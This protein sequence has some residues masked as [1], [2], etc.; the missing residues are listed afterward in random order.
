[1]LGEGELSLPRGDLDVRLRRFVEESWARS[2]T[3]GIDPRHLRRQA[4][5]RATL[6][7][8]QERARALLEAA[9]PAVAL[10]HA[11]LHNEPHMVALSDAEGFIIRLAASEPHEEAINFFEGASWHEHDIGTNGIGTALAARAPVLVTGPEH[12]V[13]DYRHWTCVGV[14]LRGPDGRVL[15]ALDLSV[16]NER[17]NPHTWGWTLSLA[18]SIE[19]QLART[20][21]PATFTS[22]ELEAINGPAGLRA[23]VRR[24]LQD[25]RRLEDWDRRKDS[26]FATLSHE[27]NSPLG[28][29]VLSVELL[30]RARL[31]PRRL[32]EA[33]G[34]LRHQLGRL[35]RIVDDIGDLARVKSG[36]LIVRKQRVDLNAVL[37]D[38]ADA[39]RPHMRAALHTLVLREA[40][41]PLFVDG[42]PDRL[43]QVFTN[44]LNN[45]AK[46]TP[47]GGTV[48][49]DADSTGHD[50]RVRVRDNGRGIAPEDLSRIFLEFTR[51]AHPHDD[52]GGL[53]I[54][55]ALVRSIIRLHGGAVTAHSEGR[56]RGS[57]FEI[58]L[59]LAPG[60]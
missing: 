30:E 17:M 5:D 34:R 19:A 14:P 16:Q 57:E 56:G 27:L 55:L 15:G 24:L 12:F 38:A 50:A 45:A 58:L 9:D 49:V 35:A 10:A 20:I 59:P 51:A 18:D 11:A 41:S 8:H 31:N 53:G 29:M 13:H 42:D 33:T 32:D 48:V 22:E 44:V 7:P 39:V 36:A 3:Y 43:E 60:R 46:Y 2:L 1:M 26:A 23:A 37:N 25:R 40:P 21:V 47:P 4:P 54:G 28:A 6:A 52:P